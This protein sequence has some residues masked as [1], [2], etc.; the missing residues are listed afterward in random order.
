MSTYS[1]EVASRRTPYNDGYETCERTLAELRIYGD[2]LD[3]EEV[4]E[5]L[6]LE[7]TTI[8]RKGEVVTNSLGRQRVV[9]IG[10]WF[11]SSENH[12]ASK[13]LRRHLD[14]LNN[15]IAP[16]VAEL[17]DIQERQDIVMTV[18]CIWWSAH[19]QGGPTL[20]PEQ[21]RVLAELN[22]ECSFDISFYGDDEE[23]ETMEPREGKA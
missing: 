8:Q 15:L 4:T 22:L 11:L 18:H 9:K 1:R 5:R 16:R 10:G 20:W 3:P 13:D 6:Q 14:W 17:R 19:G 21:M 23:Q 12:V 2:H 7:P